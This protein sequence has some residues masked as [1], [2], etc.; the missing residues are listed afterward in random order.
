MGYFSIK[1][2][3]NVVKPIQKLN[4]ALRALFHKEKSNQRRTKA[5]IRSTSQEARNDNYTLSYAFAYGRIN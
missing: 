1:N 5:S 3:N 2:Q 4:A